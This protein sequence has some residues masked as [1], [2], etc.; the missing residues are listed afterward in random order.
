MLS[1]LFI[2]GMLTLLLASCG[3]RGALEPPPG[4]E[5]RQDGALVLDGLVKSND[6]P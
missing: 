4:Q 2:A 3:A 6:S 1:R 5:P